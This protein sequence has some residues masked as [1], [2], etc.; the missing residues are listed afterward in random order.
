[1]QVTVRILPARSKLWSN[2][3]QITDTYAATTARAWRWQLT[4]AALPWS[5]R[6][7][8]FTTLRADAAGDDLAGGRYPE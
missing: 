7:I 2:Y 5:V 4:E 8:S 1:M 6:A 3:D